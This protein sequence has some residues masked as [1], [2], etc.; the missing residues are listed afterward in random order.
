MCCSQ[1][2]EK[3]GSLPAER[4]PLNWAGGCPL[5]ALMAPQAEPALP[6]MFP[7]PPLRA[8]SL[9]QAPLDWVLLQGRDQGFPQPSTQRLKEENKLTDWGGEVGELG[10]GG[11]R[12]RY[13]KYKKVQRN[14]IQS[15]CCYSKWLKNSPLICFQSQIKGCTWKSIFL[16]YRN[17]SF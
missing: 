16:L 5:W 6:Q 12:N 11:V 13:R 10:A 3:T 15:S 9:H 1:R 14:I 8:R 4:V 7:D 17:T 2:K